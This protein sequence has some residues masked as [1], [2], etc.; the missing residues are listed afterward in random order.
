MAGTRVP[1]TEMSQHSVPV[2][3]PPAG[4][5]GFPVGDLHFPASH[6]LEQQSAFESHV[7]APP[8]VFAGS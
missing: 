4:T 6:Q 2:Q 1:L 5:Q 3:L 8:A 7:P